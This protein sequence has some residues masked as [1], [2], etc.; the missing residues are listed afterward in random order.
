MSE[1]LTSMVPKRFAANNDA[2][3][4]MTN[5]STA[6]LL[7]RD[8]VDLELNWSLDNYYCER[9]MCFS[10]KLIQEF[11]FHKN[12]AFDFLVNTDLVFK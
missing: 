2:L 10:L 1:I 7:L 4:Q 12:L 6:Q 9:W 5:T 11:S 3:L 8:S